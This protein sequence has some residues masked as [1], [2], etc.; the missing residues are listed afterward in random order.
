MLSVVGRRRLSRLIIRGSPHN[1]A[2]RDNLFY[3]LQHHRRKGTRS[4]TAVVAVHETCILEKKLQQR[5]NT[6]Y[7]LSYTDIILFALM[8]TKPCASIMTIII[9]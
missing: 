9:I 1:S 6:S 2:A 8:T 3:V 4:L 5:E 7:E